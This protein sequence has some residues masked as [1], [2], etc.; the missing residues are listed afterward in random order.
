MRVSTTLSVT[1]ILIGYTS[2]AHLEFIDYVPHRH[3]IADDGA[4]TWVRDDYARP[5]KSLPLIFWEDG[6]PWN[7]ANY[8]AHERATSGSVELKTVQDVARHTNFFL[9]L[10]C[11]LKI[12]Y[13]SLIH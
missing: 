9:P 6:T 3:V 2:V 11:L 10:V 1:S 13:G 4:V 7:E 5:I 12:F 8:W